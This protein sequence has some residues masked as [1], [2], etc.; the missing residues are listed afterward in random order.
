MMEAKILVEKGESDRAREVGKQAVDL[1]EDWSPAI[2]PISRAATG[3]PTSCV[4]F[5]TMVTSPESARSNARRSNEIYMALLR[6]SPQA[7]EAAG[8]IGEF[9]LNL[10]NIG[11]EYFREAES[12]S[13]ERKLDLLRMAIESFRDGWQFCIEHVESRDRQDRV[14]F[15]LTLNERYLCRAYRVQAKLLRDPHQS[16]EALKEAIEWGKKAITDSQA[17]ADLDPSHF[18]HSWDLHLAQRE[19]GELYLAFQD[20]A[21]AIAFYNKARET[22]K[23]MAARHGKLVSRVALLQ[24]WLAVPGPQLVDGL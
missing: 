20:G 22:L 7:Q 4:Q 8:W 6:E 12:A 14:L 3:W 23:T 16:S 21:S 5:S 13:G 19:L 18:Q 15:P 17:L 24:E 9:A 2:P 11:N 1:L 10:H